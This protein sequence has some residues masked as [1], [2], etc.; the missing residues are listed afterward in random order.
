MANY[1]TL[2]ESL[3]HM[4]WVCAADGGCRAVSS[5]WVDYTGQPRA[6]QLGDRWFKHVHPDDLAPIV[7]RWAD[8]VREHAVF[9]TELRLRR[10]DG[11]Y[12]WFKTRAVPVESDGQH[13]WCGSNT[14]IQDLKDAR[15]ETEAANLALV[16][17]VTARTE[18][19]HA[20]ERLARLAEQLEIAQ[21]VSQ[22]GSWSFDIASGVVLWSDELFRIFRMPV[23]P[24]APSFEAQEAIYTPESW[25]VLQAHVVRA[26]ASGG[27]YELTLNFVRS[28]G[29]AGI[30]VA[31]GE[32]ITDAAGVIIS[33][34]GTLQDVTERELTTRALRVTSERLDLARKAAKLGIWE[35]DVRSDTL[36]WD[37][38]MYQL[39][40]IAP[41]ASIVAG[42]AWRNA[43]HPDD[44]ASTNAALVD[45]L[46]GRGEFDVDFR[47]I[48]PTGD[49]RRIRA[50]AHLERDLDGAPRR[51]IGVNKDITTQWLAEQ[52]RHTSEALQRAVFAHS[53]AAII[54]TDTTGTITLFSNAAELML[55]YTA[56][57]LVGKASPAIIHDAAEV[58]ARKAVLEA[59]LK[60]PLANLFE[61]FVVKARSLAADVNE[62]TYV[63]K[64]GQRIPVL[65]TVTVLRD[66]DGAVTGY[67]GVAVDLTQRKRV[68]QQLLGLS[69]QR[70]VLLQEIHHRV[71][72][73]LQVIASLINLQCDQINDAAARAALMV[74]RTR[75][76]TIALVHEQLYSSRDYACIP[77]AAY[78]TQLARNIFAASGADDR[79]ALTFD[80]SPVSLTVDKA[81]P[82]GLILSELLT[83]AIKHAF[84]GSKTG[85]VEVHLSCHDGEVVL[86]VSDNGVGSASVPSP[87]STSLGL[88]LVSTLASQLDGRVTTSR[89]VGTRSE[90]R[91]PLTSSED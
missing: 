80:I 5:Q 60:A 7:E 3:P 9:D 48:T 2:V 43:L 71:K 56:T 20:N 54:A 13:L 88:Q 87:N 77:F 91:F 50:G 81:V 58:L 62:W 12:R 31:R 70:E 6:E 26:M 89:V 82:C 21:R 59:E 44:A 29:D 8:A 45:A 28:D 55:G 32:A 75:V 74:C 86:V 64:H 61:V 22:V 37:A 33:L 11:V 38:G 49:V 46:E 67:L 52:A 34:I 18:L 68:E 24:I 57:E 53:G 25:A 16:S 78:A 36:I 14:D 35:W 79:I 47:V 42:E 30:A 4:A 23:Q 90:L 63:G 15:S 39:Y 51:M 27:T 76:Q 85:A 10:H 40:G 84:P 17:R 69:T 1:Q 83:N 66:D 41:D 19:E 72:N 73:N 65:L